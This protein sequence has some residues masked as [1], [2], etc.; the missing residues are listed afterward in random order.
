MRTFRSGTGNA[1]ISPAPDDFEGRDVSVA[2]GSIL[3]TALLK[4]A[5][6]NRDE[7]LAELS[8]LT[9][10]EVEERLATW[11]TEQLLLAQEHYGRQI[12]GK[13][14]QADQIDQP[15]SGVSKFVTDRTIAASLIALSL[16]LAALIWRGGYEVAGSSVGAYVVN[17][18]TGETWQCLDTCV[19]LET[20]TPEK[21]SK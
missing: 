3:T 17:R 14:P 21:K 4:G 15:K 19:R 5:G 2:I 16:V 18:F 9:P 20:F 13:A 6:M 7:F 12:P 8:Q 1:L 10:R 11:D